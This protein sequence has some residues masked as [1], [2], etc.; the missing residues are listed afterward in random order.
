MQTSALVLAATCGLNAGLFTSDYS[1][2]IASVAAVSGHDPQ[3]HDRWR[4]P[5]LASGG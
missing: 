5:I 2:T 3:R 1:R 4:D